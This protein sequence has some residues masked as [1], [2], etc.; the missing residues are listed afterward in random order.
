MDGSSNLKMDEKEID[1]TNNLKKDEKEMSKEMEKKNKKI[2]EKINVF[3]T[4]LS[5]LAYLITFI[6]IIVWLFKILLNAKSEP[7]NRNIYIK[8]DPSNYYEE[9]EFCYDNYKNFIIKGVL[10][11]FDIP[12]KNIRKY[13]KVLLST[14]FISIDSLVITNILINITKSQ[15]ISCV[16]CFFIIF[17]LAL[18]LS[19]AFA[20]V[21]AHYYF[22]GN[23]NNF[24]E[25][26]RCRYL[27]KKF[28]TDYDFIFKIKNEFNMPFVL[29]LI[30]EFCNFFKL[31]VESEDLVKK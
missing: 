1:G 7:S 5:L 18:I 28:K 16:K 20:I 8:K 9:G 26:S 23:Y 19:I 17:I 30:L 21:F 25:F 6:L 15:C 2:K 12:I 11:N 3:V 27:T 4:A 22:N 24:E 10:D 29:I 13:A 14:I 31:L